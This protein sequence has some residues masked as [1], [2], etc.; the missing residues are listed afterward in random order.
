MLEIGTKF[1]DNIWEIML[2]TDSKLQSV[3]LEKMFDTDAKYKLTF[4]KV[5]LAL[6]PCFKVTLIEIMLDTETEF[7]NE[8]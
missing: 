2:G 8:M 4:K 7:Q 5:C 3:I 1:Q 6:I